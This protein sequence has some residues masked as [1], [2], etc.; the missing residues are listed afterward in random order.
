MK[1]IFLSDVKSQGKKD[2]IKE[3]KDGYARY[4]ISSKLA[5]PYTEK[6][7]EIL[8]KEKQQKEQIEANNILEA[9]KLKA[10]L[11]KVKLE[12]VVKTGEKDK[13]FGSVSSKVIH[14]ELQKKGFNIDKKK[15]KIKSELNTLGYHDVEI[16]LY[17]N[18]SCTI[19]VLI[20]K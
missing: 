18:I 16:E 6:G 2:E 15:I 14:E 11:E 7:M 5:V 12:F 4:L 13:V 3:V 17:K 1:V 10:K 8:Q 9:N 19:K 20:K